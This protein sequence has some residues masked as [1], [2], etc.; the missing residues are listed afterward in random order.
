MKKLTKKQLFIIS[1]ALIIIDVIA[2]IVLGVF[3]WLTYESQSFAAT[4]RILTSA[5]V[6][7]DP[8][9]GDCL[10]TNGATSTWEA[11]CG[12]GGGGDGA[13]ATTTSSVD[14]E[15]IIY[16]LNVSDTLVIGSNATGTAEFWIDPNTDEIH[17]GTVIAG[18]WNGD[19]IDELYG[20]T[21]T[22]SPSRFFFGDGTSIVSTS[23]ISA[24]YIDDLL[25]RDSELHNAVT[26]AGEDYLSL[27]TQEITAN[28][29]NPDNLASADFGDFT[30]NG[31]TCSLDTTYLVASDIANYTFTSLTSSGLVITGT[32]TLGNASSTSF[33]ITGGKLINSSSATSSFTGGISANALSLGHIAGCG[34]LET[35]ASGAVIC[36]TDSG[37]GGDPGLVVSLV[38]TTDYNTASTTGRAF[39]FNDGFV[40]SGASSTISDVLHLAGN[41]FASSSVIHFENALNET[42]GGTGTSSPQRFLF[43]SSGVLTSTSTISKQF[44]DSSLILD[45]EIDTYTELNTLVS[46]VTLTHNGLIDSFSEL[47][48]IVADKSLANLDDAQTFAGALTFSAGFTASSSVHFDSATT[49][50]LGLNGKITSNGTA[51]SSFAGGLSI[52]TLTVS[53]IVSCGALET[54]ASGALICGTDA[55]GGG[56]PGL[57]VQTIGTTDYNT[58]STTGRAFRF[59]D[60]F[61]SVGSSTVNGSFDIDGSLSA[62]STHLGAGTSTS[63][64]VSGA[65]RVSGLFRALSGAIISSFLQIPNGASPTVDNDGEI[66]VDTSEEEYDQLVF[67]GDETNSI[68]P[69]SFSFALASSTPQGN[70][71]SGTTTHSFPGKPYGMTLSEVACDIDTGTHAHIQFGDGSASSTLQE[72]TTT[73]SAFDLATNNTY[74]RYERLYFSVGATAGTPNYV[75]CTVLYKPTRS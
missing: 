31:T 51:T 75:N 16:P 62:S 50:D 38:G 10:T 41:I 66:A 3:S 73:I 53:D 57:I 24:T 43:G 59:N 17:I 27:S 46:D 42:E 69:P 9:D 58:A 30:C 74:T 25:A 32:S 14:G 15:L 48:T 33:G 36:G 22:S 35:N 49:T 65:S 18:T 13:F 1:V 52:K 44:L 7:S 4:P 61:I 68:V 63:W 39:R 71:N 2:F 47:D 11:T 6:G 28:A 8:D 20:G 72:A 54:D 45:S 70:F 55:G 5:Q 67:D 34:A 19:V 12:V 23:S 26:L 21:G 56:D 40:S 60:G 37:G 64:F 29:I